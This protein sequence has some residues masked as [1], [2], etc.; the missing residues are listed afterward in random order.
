VTAVAGGPWTAAPDALPGTPARRVVLT[1]ERSLE[2]VVD[3]LPAAGPDDLLLR[4]ALCGICATDRL[5]LCNED[6]PFEE[7][8]FVGRQYGCNMAG[9]RAPGLWGGYA[10][11]PW[12][13]AA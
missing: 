11:D 12:G 5:N 2:V 7:G 8:G 10:V 13:R 1:G 3:P 4:V 6:D 9:D